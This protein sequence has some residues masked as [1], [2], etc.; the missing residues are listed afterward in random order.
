MAISG[1]TR[2]ECTNALRAAFGNADRAFEFLLSGIPV[3]GSQQNDYGDEEPA[4]ANN[5]G[6]GNPFAALANNPNFE[7][8][9]QRILQN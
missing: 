8:I 7:I 2:E 4:D 3:E 6:A 1:K 9:R 5:P